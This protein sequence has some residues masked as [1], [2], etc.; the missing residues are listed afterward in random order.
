MFWSVSVHVHLYDMGEQ[1]AYFAFDPA[2]QELHGYN[3]TQG[4]ALDHLTPQHF[5]P[6]VKKA[7]KKHQAP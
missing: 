1:V 4:V 7:R 6:S 2:F 3:K 5:D